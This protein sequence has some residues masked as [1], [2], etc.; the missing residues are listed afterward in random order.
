M[1]STPI[2]LSNA[3]V[4][5][6]EPPPASSSAGVSVVLF[7]DTGRHATVVRKL[8]QYFQS[9]GLPFELISVNATGPQLTPLSDCPQLQ[10]TTGVDAA[11]RFSRFSKM[12][13]VDN[14]FDFDAKQY[15]LLAA[16]SSL[17]DF[18]AW[19]WRHSRPPRS[20][21]LLVGLFVIIS[22]LVLGVRKTRISPGMVL[23]N[24]SALEKLNLAYV[25]HQ[26]ADAPG[27]L[28]AL[29][30]REGHAVQEHVCLEP[31]P[32]TIWTKSN[33]AEP[34]F[35]KSRSIKRSIFN[36][37]FFWFNA[38]A[39]PATTADTNTLGAT[40]VSRTAVRSRQIFAAAALLF[41]AAFLMLFNADYPLFEPDE[42]RNAQLALNIVESGNWMALTLNGEPYWDK[43]PMLAWLTAISYRTFGVNEF[44]TR[45]P[46]IVAS[47]SMLAMML[48]IGRR[49][50]GFRAAWLG[51]AATTLGWGMLFQIR[52]V[53]M[54]ALLTCF[55]TISLLTL[56]YSV[57]SNG[58][59][60]RWGVVFSGMFAGLGVLTKGP[61]CLVILGPP[62]LAWLLLH[63]FGS[64]K[65]TRKVLKRFLIAMSLVGVPWFAIT[66]WRD[67]QFA[68]YFF[69]K[70]H[71]VRFSDAFNHRE[72]F[73]FYVP[74]LFGFMFPASILIP[75]V[76]RFLCS[77]KP[78]SRALRAPEHGVLAFA[79][80]WT[81]GFFSLSDCKLPAY[82][83]P[84]FPLM[85]L[86]IGV[87]LEQIFAGYEKAN[88]QALHSGVTRTRNR[89][90]RL[91][92]RIAIG[93]AV[94]TL[95][96]S[97]LV[98]F[99]FTEYQLPLLYGSAMTIMI[100]SFLVI[101]V[102]K[103]TPHSTAWL[104]T[105]GLCVLFVSTGINQLVPSISSQRSIL[106]SLANRE[107]SSNFENEAGQPLVY[108]GRDAFA[109]KL[110]LPGREVSYIREEALPAMNRFLTQNPNATIVATRENI[111]RIIESIDV[112]LE[113]ESLGPRHVFQSRAVASSVAER[114]DAKKLR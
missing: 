85:G 38:L 114:A 31:Q 95:I 63:R 70:H 24:K 86:L 55:T 25:N 67:P 48:L 4:S 7:E 91:P 65:Q 76:I 29:A 28:L 40:S 71:V 87:V 54:D 18:Q 46:S 11:I 42:T 2:N 94:L 47:L 106:A 110:Y 43:P 57:S 79:V 27:Q 20:R 98:R 61:I 101:A 35:P 73:W 90:D 26:S 39:F 66:I 37:L 84:A 97:C 52:Y 13:F 68:Q 14:N 100:V 96:V 45:L 9:R 15:E 74:V 8:C 108:F 19:S 56:L 12:L 44:A 49:L 92:K 41:V 62:M 77:S 32:N 30:K 22:R 103:A 88:L 93:I 102:R 53:T 10:S 83:L 58:K 81:M 82:L 104:A 36:H 17:A 113:F 60:R 6:A 5:A 89:L 23:I 34:N 3:P 75:Q 1:E 78:E 80:I 107:Q 59:L 33:T 72:A 51:A 105:G 99:K 16:D 50:F 21:R 64:K 112:E 111:Q 69:W 109:T